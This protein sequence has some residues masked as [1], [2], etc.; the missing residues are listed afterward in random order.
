MKKRATTLAKAFTLLELTIAMMVGL[1]VATLIISLFNQQLAFLR[2]YQ[3]QNFLTD[4][5][6]VINTY[7]TRLI[8]G[9]DRIRLH[10]TVTDAINGTNARASASPVMVLNFRQADGTMR[11]SILSFE[12]RSGVKALYYYIVPKTGA[13]G[14]P[15][16]FITRRASNVLF[17]LDQG[18][19]RFNITGPASESITYAVTMQQ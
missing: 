15:Q 8:T 1:I 17:S 6:P 9:A 14:N 12:T 18:V 16:W 7:V 5:A 2:I 11:A 4:E 13:L 10:S 19:I 3:A